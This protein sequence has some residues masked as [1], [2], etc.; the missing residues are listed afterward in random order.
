[1]KFIAV[2]TLFAAVFTTLVQATPTPTSGHIP[3]LLARN[4]AK[5]QTSAD[6]SATEFF[7]STRSCCLSKGGPK[8]TPK[9]P[10]GVQCP[11]CMSH[12]SRHS[13]NF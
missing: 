13:A 8:T 2:V 4:S 7:Y 1:M 9:A 10:S 11:S 6:C 3:D 12:P 5:K